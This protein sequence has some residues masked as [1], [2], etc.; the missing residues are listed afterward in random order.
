MYAG[1]KVEEG[2]L[3]DVFERPAHPYTRGLLRAASLAGGVNG[4]LPEISGTVPS[5]FEMPAGCRFAPRCAHVQDICR[6]AL[7]PLRHAAPDHVAACVWIG[8]GAP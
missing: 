4:R 3:S 2:S 1:R 6:A 8:S 7:P 5:P